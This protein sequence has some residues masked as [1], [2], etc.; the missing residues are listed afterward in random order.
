ML[1]TLGEKLLFGIGA[2]TLVLALIL[3]LGHV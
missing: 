2:I 3:E 1:E